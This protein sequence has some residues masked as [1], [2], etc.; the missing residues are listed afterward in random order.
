MVKKNWRSHGNLAQRQLAA[1]LASRR[2]QHWATEAAEFL[3][4]TTQTY[5]E[6]ELDSYQRQRER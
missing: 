5:E 4:L 3:L 2:Q 1:N 6:Q